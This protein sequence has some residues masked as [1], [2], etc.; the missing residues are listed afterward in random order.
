MMRLPKPLFPIKVSPVIPVALAIISTSMT[1][2]CWLVG[3]NIY[4]ALNSAIGSQLTEQTIPVVNT[5]RTEWIAIPIA[6]TVCMWIWVFMVT[7]RRQA[8]TVPY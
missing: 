2:L 5:L 1:F 4:S 6:I 8:V 3:E 7:T